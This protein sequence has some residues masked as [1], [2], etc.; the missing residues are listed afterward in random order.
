MGCRQYCHLNLPN[1]RNTRFE[2][3]DGYNSHAAEALSRLVEMLLILSP[4]GV[5]LECGVFGE[6]DPPSTTTS[7]LVRE[8]LGFRR[9]YIKTHP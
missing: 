5:A 1:R 9:L 6:F 4:A 2:T 7:S 3:L 8:L